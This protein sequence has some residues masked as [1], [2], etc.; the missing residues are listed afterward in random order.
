[1]YNKINSIIIY[2]VH[3]ILSLKH[4]LQ[5]GIKGLKSIHMDNL[6]IVWAIKRFNKKLFQL[7]YIFVAIVKDH[8]FVSFTGMILKHP[9]LSHS[10]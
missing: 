10:Q 4:P 8:I 5:D 2:T 3:N 1:M 7:V 6:V 9:I